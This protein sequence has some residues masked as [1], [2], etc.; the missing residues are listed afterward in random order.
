MALLAWLME[1]N[2]FWLDKK[3]KRKSKYKTIQIASPSNPA[4]YLES[5]WLHL[6]IKCY[7]KNAFV[8]ISTISLQIENY[9]RFSF[10]ASKTVG[11]NTPCYAPW[12]H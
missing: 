6:R 9:F 7:W 11:S 3:Q 12:S 8:M 1:V 5:I 2:N 4:I 10:T